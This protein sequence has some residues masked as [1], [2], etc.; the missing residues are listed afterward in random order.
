MRKTQTSHY[1]VGRTSFLLSLFLLGLL[2]ASDLRG[3][4]PPA[5]RPSPPEGTAVAE[6]LPAD[7]AG[8]SEPLPAAP[9]PLA[10]SEDKDDRHGFLRRSV[11]K[12]LGLD[13]HGDGESKDGGGPHLGPLYPS[14]TVVSSG[15]GIAP[16]LQL[17]APDL[18]D[19]GLDVQGAA[20]YSTRRYEFYAIR[21]G[22]LPHRGAG[23]PWLAT[24]T[25]RLYPLSDIE[26]LSRVE[27]RFDLYGAY[28]YRYYPE[29]DF[30]GIGIDSQAG[31]RTDYR[32]FDQLAEVVTA[33]H[34]TPRVALTARAGVQRTSLGPGDDPAF[35]DLE[36]RFDSVTAP[37]LV[38]QPDQ[39]ILSSGLLLDFRDEPGNPHGG[40]FLAVGVS[41]YDDR[42]G[43]Q[44]EFQRAAGDLRLYLPLGSQRHV[45]AGH[46]VASFDFTDPGRRVPFYLQSTLGGSLL[47]RG[48]PSSRFR[49]QKLIAFTGEYRFEVVPRLELALFYDAGQTVP[50]LDD[51]DLSRLHTS[52]GAGLRL[53]SPRK[54]RVRFDVAHSSEDTRYLVR[55]SPAF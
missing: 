6:P 34:F 19:S 42:N 48:F 36:T 50:G 16:M 25:S 3:D 53:K 27:N 35:P 31:D 47:L 32:L 10:R 15:G 44:F 11:D 4:D 28:R 2:G 24:S 7:T 38:R 30:Y 8:A 20:S 22:L 45:L 29:E 52:Y 37:G 33:Y 54:L 23:P 14:V 49:D 51:L 5:P 43:S 18:G 40:V 12:A 13:D 39:V 55:F 9:A 17:W 46:A 26:H 1:S 41:R 21:V